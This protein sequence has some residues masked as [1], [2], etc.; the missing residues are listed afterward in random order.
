MA[1]YGIG[2]DYAG[3]YVG[4]GFYTKSIT[5]ISYGLEDKPYLYGMSK[6]IDIGDIVIQR[7][8]FTG[9]LV[10]LFAWM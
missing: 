1:I 8:A 2:C 7:E 5:R 3:K 4:N 10:P 6:E 9:M